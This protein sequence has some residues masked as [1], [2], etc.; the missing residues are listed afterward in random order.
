VCPEAIFD[1]GRP[2]PDESSAYHEA[3]HAVAA[4]ALGIGFD[5]VSVVDDRNT[6]GRI[7]LDQGWP[8]RR[9]GFDPSAVLDRRVAEDWILLALAGEFA[10]A[11]HIGLDPDWNSHG[12][13]SDFGV[14]AAVAE[15]LF[16]HPRESDAFLKEMCSRAHLFV[17]EP[18]RWRQISAVATQLVRLHVLD[19]RQ[20][21]TIMDDVATVGETAGTD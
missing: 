12:A 4:V 8:H 14:A 21:G 9:P 11:Y 18:L 3:A 19:W 20:V 17:S 15:R 6:L 1:G 2:K 10:S 16:V 7:V 5:H 13:S